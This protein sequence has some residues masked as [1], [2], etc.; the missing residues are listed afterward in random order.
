MKY[1]FIGGELHGQVMHVNDSVN[2][3]KHVIESEPKRMNH[4]D[5]DYCPIED[6]C[7]EF[8]YRREILE[9]T[10][11]IGKDRHD[12][13]QVFF[14]TS[15]PSGAGDAFLNDA[16]TIARARCRNER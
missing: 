16:E 15:I 9:Q 5:A 3:Y 2:Y 6:T 8:Q 13:G 12:H 10:F 4:L 11:R 14:L 1:L 7:T